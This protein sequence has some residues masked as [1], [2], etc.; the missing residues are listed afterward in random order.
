MSD[1]GSKNELLKKRIHFVGIGGAGLSAI[2]RVLMEKGAPISGS[3][4]V[5]SP[6]AEALK[7][8][9]ARVVAGHKASMLHDFERGRPLEIDALTNAV[10]EI[11]RVNGVPTP[12]LDEVS[13][14]V[15]GLTGR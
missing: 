9:G 2:A 4:L 5:L 14:D 3:D 6:V 13:G 11:G 15:A 8:D 7:R 12:S 10:R 1:N